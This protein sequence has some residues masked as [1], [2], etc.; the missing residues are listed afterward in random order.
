MSCKF[1]EFFLVIC[2]LQLAVLGFADE[3]PAVDSEVDGGIAQTVPDNLNVLGIFD[4]IESM[5]F[6]IGDTKEGKSKVQPTIRIASFD[7]PNP[8]KELWREI[9]TEE[10]HVSV[11]PFKPFI[12]NPRV[13]SSPQWKFL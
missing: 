1:K 3:S 11:L 2:S 10:R 12:L 5:S 9:E 6:D 8:R 4:Q 7:E 13:P